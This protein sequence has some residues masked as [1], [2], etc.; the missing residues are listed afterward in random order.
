LVYHSPHPDQLL[1]QGDVISGE[2]VIPG[3]TLPISELFAELEF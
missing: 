3:F 1:R 2:K